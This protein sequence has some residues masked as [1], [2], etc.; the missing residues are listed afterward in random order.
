[1]IKILENNEKNLSRKLWERVFK[2]DSKN[3]LDYYYEEKTK[4]NI[5]FAKFHDNDIISMLHL[6]PYE[7]VLKNN[8]FLCYYIVAV[9]TDLNHR[10]NGYMKNIMYKSL[11][12]MYE[13]NCPFTFLMP[14]KKEIYTPFDFATIYEH[15]KIELNKNI[16]IIEEN[17]LKN[18][19]FENL[20]IF[21]ND[22]L[23]NT[24]DVFTLKT[25]DYI[26]T[27]YK[28]LK[29]EN[30]D[31]K[32]ILENDNIVACY[33]YYINNNKQDIRSAFGLNKYFILNETKHTIMAR[34][35]NLNSFL[36]NIKLK[37]SC[38]EDHLNIC[39]NIKD[40]I[41][42]K[43]NN[44]FNWKISKLS[45][46]IS[47]LN[48]L[49]INNYNFLNLNISDLTSWLF[50]YKSI[51]EIFDELNINNKQLLQDLQKIQTFKNIFIDDI[52]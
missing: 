40:K 7:L 17:F 19:N 47:P 25:S 46:K 10:K 23:K 14:A 41:I 9:A 6:N 13:K 37:A 51:N 31:F 22:Y 4:N 48:N 27:L 2:E 32:I 42:S 52:V 8:N 28:E 39:I 36:S 49:N 24:Y 26:Q 20:S 29:S 3:F 45:S 15:K 43:N 44:T 21:I 18:T 5:I 33:F 11:N 30:G 12:F 1:M 50:G 16:K 34:I 38:L 35:I